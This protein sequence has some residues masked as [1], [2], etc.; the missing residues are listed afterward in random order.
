[1]PCEAK[2]TP[3]GHG[4][5]CSITSMGLGWATGEWNSPAVVMAL[6]VLQSSIFFFLGK[7]PDHWVKRVGVVVGW[8]L[9]KAIKSSGA[10]LVAVQP[11]SS[12]TPAVSQGAKKPKRR[13]TEFVV[14]MPSD[15]EDEDTD[16]SDGRVRLPCKFG[17]FI[18]FFISLVTHNGWDS[19]HFHRT[20]VAYATTTCALTNQYR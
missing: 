1:M 17:L 18:C 6:H 16:T 20:H 4:F 5:G 10:A 9:G 15:S 19:I 14:H 7:F 8:E 13:P 12:F 3:E 2:E 11:L